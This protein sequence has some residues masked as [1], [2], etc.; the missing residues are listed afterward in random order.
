M[1][2]GITLKNPNIYIKLAER[3]R[4]RVQ[5]FF[6]IPSGSLAWRPRTDLGRPDGL[7]LDDVASSSSGTRTTWCFQNRICIVSPRKYRRILWAHATNTFYQAGGAPWWM[8]T[9]EFH[10]VNL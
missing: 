10:W 2:R 9:Q 1:I 6:L 7:D 5:P 8:S 4:E 3:H